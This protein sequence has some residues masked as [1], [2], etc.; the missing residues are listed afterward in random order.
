MKLLIIFGTLTITL[1]LSNALIFHD[2][3]RPFRDFRQNN[4]FG[5]FKS[6]SRDQFIAYLNAYRQQN[7]RNIPSGSIE[8]K[9]GNVNSTQAGATNPQP[10]NSHHSLPNGI[11]HTTEP[12]EP[13]SQSSNEGE[14]P[15]PT[16][17]NNE[18]NNDGS[19]NILTKHPIS[20]VNEEKEEPLFGSGETPHV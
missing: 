7:D 17:E 5:T 1:A 12:V 6:R 4:L 2:D 9:V 8:N 11:K 13:T 15:V 16:E 3:F 10:V 19:D 18:V 14:T 20:C